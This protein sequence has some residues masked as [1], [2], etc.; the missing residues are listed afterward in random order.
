MLVQVIK[1]DDVH[2]RVLR[3][4]RPAHWAPGVVGVGIAGG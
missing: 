3:D 2:E 4:S 1:W